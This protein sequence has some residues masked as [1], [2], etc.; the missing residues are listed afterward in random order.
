MII[1]VSR[2]DTKALG[3]YLN[4][5]KEAAAS[6]PGLPVPEY[7]AVALTDFVELAETLKAQVNHDAVTFDGLVDTIR[8]EVTPELA[9][10]FFDLS[11]EYIDLIVD[12]A[13]I[14]MPLV[15]TLKRGLSR[16]QESADALKDWILRKQ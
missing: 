3:I 2:E 10:R 7:P 11:G 6:V 15:R 5:I 9:R 4:K 8:I 12:L 13:V 1:I 16:A 14:I